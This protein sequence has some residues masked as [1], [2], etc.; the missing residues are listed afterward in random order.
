MSQHPILEADLI[1]GRACS[2]RDYAVVYPQAQFTTR[3]DGSFHWGFTTGHSLL[4]PSIISDC[5]LSDPQNSARK[6]QR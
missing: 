2:D 4:W 3:G 6:V 1:E 5:S